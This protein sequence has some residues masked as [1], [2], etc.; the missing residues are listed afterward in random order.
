MTT[1]ATHHRIPLLRLRVP[2]PRARMAGALLL[3]LLIAFGWLVPLWHD[4][5]PHHQDLMHTLTPPGAEHLLGTDPLG[6]SMLGRLTE[7]VR[8]SLGLAL[9][10]VASAAVPGV[11]FG[12]IAGWRPGLVDRSLGLVADVVLALPGLLLVLLLAAIAPGTF[13]SLYVGI[14]LVLW[15]EYFR[16]VRTATRTLISAPQVQCA[17]M[18]GFGPGYIFRR[19]LWPELAP[20]VTTL[21]A[22]G[23]S[24]AVLAVSSL[25]FVS[26]GLRPPTAELGLMMTELFPFYQEAPWLLAQPVIM[27]FLM[28]LSFQL[29]AGREPQ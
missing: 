14:A 2:L 11:V 26:I 5:S 9:L 1:T 8:L 17:R 12:V 27:L 25:G 7:A 6:R 10:S 13:W 23:A 29:L 19:H 18:L 24:T 21:A 16:V 15:V 20:E 4:V 22:F 28:V 3:A